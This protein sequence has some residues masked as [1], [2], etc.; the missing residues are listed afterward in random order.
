M[1]RK[2]IP[3]K[4]RFEVFKRD[5]FRCQYC[6]ATA[7]DVLLEIDHIHPVA[8]G[9]TNEL[10]NLVT[11]CKAC[12]AGKGKRRISDGSALAKQREQLEE[13]NERREQLEMMIRWKEELTELQE[14]SLR[15]VAEY[16]AKLAPGFSLNE[17][18]HQ[19]LR[20]LLNQFPLS[21]VMDAMQTAAAQYLRYSDEKLD[22]A[23]VEVA[24]QKVGG[25]CRTRKA[26]E[27][28]P[29]LRDLYY[30]RGI[31]R[32]RMYVDERRI[33]DM[34]EDAVRAGVSVEWLKERACRCRNWSEFR[35]DVEYVI[36][37][38]E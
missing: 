38:A 20:K 37:N 32:N 6:G 25:I 28:K 24:W 4:V 27:T 9:G 3:K 10:L 26:E 33:L 29:Y 31:L 11:S 13:L 7:P 2:A 19:G 21:E 18:G 14:E 8:E 36:D 22:G 12:N 15:R 16:W 17:S 35:D 5:G 1:A 30:I 34:L 23:S